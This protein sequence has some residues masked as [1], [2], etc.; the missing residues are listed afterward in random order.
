MRI[1]R[2]TGAATLALT[3]VAALSGCADN[4]KDKAFGGLGSAPNPPSLSPMP[5]PSLNG[6]IGGYANGGTSSGTS[7][8]SSRGTSGGLSS[9]LS[10]GSGS[11]GGSGDTRPT[12]RPTYN[13]SATGE[14]IGENC[15]YSRSQGRMSF[16]VDIQNSSSD[17]AFRYSFT[18]V[19]KVGRYANSTVASKTIS[20]QYKTV[21][22]SAGGDRTITVHTSH[23]TNER[24]VY[25]CQV[26]SARKYL[27]S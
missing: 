17:Y 25:S 21:T 1:R 6:A 7:G 10:G 3:A 2:A 11:G 23:S 27:A 14:V 13:R 18:V 9:G 5:M 15:R 4:P 8:G 20:S 19:F 26:K 22:V 12:A 24:L 16:D